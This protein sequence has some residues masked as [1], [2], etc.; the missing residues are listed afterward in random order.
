MVEVG[1]GHGVNFAHYPDTVTEVI[2]AEPDPTCARSPRRPR[3]PLP[4]R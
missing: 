2:A 4:N 1:A 3:A